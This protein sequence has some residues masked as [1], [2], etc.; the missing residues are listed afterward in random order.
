MPQPDKLADAV[1]HVHHEVADFQIAKIRQER[2][3]NGAMAIA[4]PVDLR[5][6]FLEDVGLGNHLKLRG[7]QAEA[8][9]ELAH[10]N[11]D[12][13]VQQLVGAVEHDAAQ[14]VF[15][16]QLHGAL[17]APFGA[18]DK[19][20]RV[21]ALANA[22]HFGDPFLDAPAKFHGRLAGD[23]EGATIGRPRRTCPTYGLYVGRVLLVRPG[24]NGGVTN[25]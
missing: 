23:I 13:D 5:A 7:G 17:G 20:H 1:V 12:R 24:V 16:Q 8:F 4:A 25:R 21:V 18:G 6:L 14:I 11:G 15:G 22:P 2:F 3:R 19:Q 9:R 10:G